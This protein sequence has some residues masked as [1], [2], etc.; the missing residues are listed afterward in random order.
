MVKK[1]GVKFQFC[2]DENINLKELKKEYDYVVLAIGAWK[3][4]KISLS[5]CDNKAINAI[6]FLEKYKKQEGNI[7]LGKKVCVIGGGDVAMDAARSAKRVSGVEEVSIIYRRT[8]KYMPAD[9]EEIELAISEGILLKEL[10]TPISIDDRKL[11]C[12][13]MILGDTDAS[14]RRSSVGTGEMTTLDADTVIIAAGEKIDSKLL[15]QNEIN[16]DSNEFPIVNEKL[17]TNIANVY[18]IGDLKKV[19]LQLLMQ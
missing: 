11:T 8:K 3:P 4:G 18:I 15:R 10:L 2:I 12:E 5:D 17:E 14:L 16:L 1:Q 13:K 6:S 7:A 9:N 19:H